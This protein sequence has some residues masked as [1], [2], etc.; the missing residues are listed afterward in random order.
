[1]FPSP[2]QQPHPDVWGLER[3]PQPLPGQSH[4]VACVHTGPARPLWHTRVC[5]PQPQEHSRSVLR[6]DQGTT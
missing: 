1:M 4:P 2:G 5:R 6:A 3:A